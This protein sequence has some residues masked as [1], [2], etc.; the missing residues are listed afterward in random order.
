MRKLLTLCLAG[1]AMLLSFA[2]RPVAA[3]DDTTTLTIHK[4]AY[5]DARLSDVDQWQY[6]NTGEALTLGDESFGLNG[7]QFAVYDA[8]TLYDSAKL[9][10][11][12][13]A[14][15]A[16]RLG[17]MDLA[18]AQALAKQHDL[19][20]ITE[21]TTAT[22]GGED[23]IASFTVP[24]YH[25]GQYAAYLLVE[26]GVTPQ[27]AINI[28]L[29]KKA[30]PLYL[31]LPARVNGTVLDTVHLYP[32]NVGYVRDPFF[33]KYGKQLDGSEQPLAGVVFAMYRLDA[34]GNKL[35][36]ANAPAVNLANQWLSSTDAL[37]DSRVAH[38][39]SDADGL[40]NTGE[41]FV[42][43]GTYYFEELKALA[44]Y[45][46][47]LKAQPVKVTVPDAWYDEKGNFLPVLINDQVLPETVAGVVSPEVRQAGKPRVYNY[48]KK[49]LVPT[50]PSKPPLASGLLPAMGQAASVGAL[51][52]GLALMGLA[53]LRLRRR[54]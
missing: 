37:N 22:V 43:S 1:V 7:A 27:T 36:L 39:T 53:A 12:T 23:G 5:R 16:K 24:T 40:V 41:R 21:V 4:R 42:A 2:A 19:P 51:L 47:N 3:A 30:A 34:S 15:F 10:D 52:I 11:E 46:N 17:K 8:S 35:Y 28:D 18:G 49:P 26:T 54:Q 13:Q 38:F 45:T 44:G 9:A 25:A 32:K 6:T 20:L 14:D 33:F 48:Q 31:Q 50:T 29:T